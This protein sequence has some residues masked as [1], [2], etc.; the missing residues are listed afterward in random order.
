MSLPFL[1]FANLLLEERFLEKFPDTTSINIVITNSRYVVLFEGFVY[2]SV[3][4]RNKNRNSLLT[5]II[6]TFSF[7]ACGYRCYIFSAKKAPVTPIIHLH[8]LIST[9]FYRLIISV[10]RARQ[11]RD[12]RNFGRQHQTFIFMYTYYCSK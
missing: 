9:K 7:S 10:S 5:T 11:R 8:C 3:L 6:P 12:L 1:K 4:K 2:S